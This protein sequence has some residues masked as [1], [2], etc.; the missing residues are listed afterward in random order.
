MEIRYYNQW[1]D[2]VDFVLFQISL[3]SCNTCSGFGF[4]LLGF[5]IEVRM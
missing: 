5:G 2:D 3:H 1:I 4:W